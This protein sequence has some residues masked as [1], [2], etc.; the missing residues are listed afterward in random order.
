MGIGRALEIHFSAEPIDAREAY[1]IGA[2]NRLVAAGQALEEAKKMIKLYEKRAPLSLAYAKRAVRA[3]M[4]MDLS[5][6]IEF[7]RFLVT[8]VYGTEDRREGIAA[9]LQKRE[10]NF[11][12]Q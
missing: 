1:R 6:A 5:S 9:F 12:G 11:K 10:A 8:S 4:Q 2:V 3:G 7:E